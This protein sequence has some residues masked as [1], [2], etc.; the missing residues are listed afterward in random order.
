MGNELKA[1]EYWNKAVFYK[2]DSPSIAKKI[3]ARKFLEE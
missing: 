2:S 1:L 3:A